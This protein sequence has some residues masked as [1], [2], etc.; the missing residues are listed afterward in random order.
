M[1]FPVLMLI[2]VL[3]KE[4]VLFGRLRIQLDLRA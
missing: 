3:K 2:T 1:A 4:D